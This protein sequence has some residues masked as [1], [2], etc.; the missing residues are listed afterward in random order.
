MLKLSFILNAFAPSTIR[1]G[2]IF[3]AVSL[4]LI[5]LNV[6]W[7]IVRAKSLAYREFHG[8]FIKVHI[9]VVLATIAVFAIE[10]FFISMVEFFKTGYFPEA[11]TLCTWLSNA[12]LV[13]ALGLS[14]AIYLFYKTDKPDYC[15]N[16][17]NRSCAACLRRICMNH[18]TYY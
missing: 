14:F 7:M 17:R 9:I 13:I 8:C 3:V 15:D 6:V 4:L 2:A 10:I 12:V 5:A 18:H 16:C 1:L 11:I